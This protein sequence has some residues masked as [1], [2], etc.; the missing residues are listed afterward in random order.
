MATLPR[1]VLDTNVCLDLFVF[2][3][4]SCATLRDA[5]RAGAVQAVTDA[6]CR[7]EW[8]R[9]LGYPQ[10]ALDAARRAAAVA[11]FDESV[12]LL[13]TA[14]RPVVPAMPKLP[15]CADPDDQRFLELA[16]ASGA[17]WLLSR[18]REL[19]K[20]ARRTRREHGFDILTPQ[21]WTRVYSA[22]AA[23]AK[24]V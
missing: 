1:L 7:D 24:P 9:V 11:A 5:L 18:D 15:R 10:L 23:S 20:L 14:G 3:D 22:G 6:A 19:L 4:A 8:L 12:R 2:G 13:P 16:Q 21:A 17:Q